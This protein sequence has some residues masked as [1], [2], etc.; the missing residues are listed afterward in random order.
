MKKKVRFFR[1]HSLETCGISCILTALD[2]YGKVK[3]PTAKQERRLYALY[4]CKA[5]KGTLAS[6]IAQCLL[7]NQLDVS[8]Y[9]SSPRYMENRNGYYPEPLYEALLA[10][11]TQTLREIEGQAHVETG[12]ALTPAWYRAQ[13]GE[14]K[15]LF[16]QCVVPGDADGMHDETLHWVL[17]YRCDEGGFWVCNPLDRKIQLTEEE[18][19]HYTDT[20]IGQVCVAVGEAR[21]TEAD[22]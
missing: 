8:L 22:P 20:P 13:L 16:V 9:H 7:R 21:K 2:Y 6:A 14:G 18:L 11:Y 15:L 5:F 10:E 17:M 3:Y 1:Q 12:C 4:G 19:I